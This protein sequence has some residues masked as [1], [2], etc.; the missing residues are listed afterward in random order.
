[1]P[2]DISDMFPLNLLLWRCINYQIFIDYSKFLRCRFPISLHCTHSQYTCI[3]I[4]MLLNLSWFMY[5]L[6]YFD[7]YV[8][9]SVRLFC[10]CELIQSVGILIQVFSRLDCGL[11]PSVTESDAL[12]SPT[13]VVERRSS[14]CFC[15][16]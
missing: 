11:A 7:I 13:A 4:F 12:R 2:P 16:I 1:M 5:A 3:M 15:Y 8:A 10:K 6:A 9:L 14:P